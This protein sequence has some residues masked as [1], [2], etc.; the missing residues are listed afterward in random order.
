MAAFARLVQDETLDHLEESDPRAIRSRADLRRIHAVMGTRHILVK[1]LRHMDI[2]PRRMIELG[3]GEASLTLRV[4]HTLAREWGPVHLTLLDRQNAV[5]PST[6]QAFCHLGWEVKLLNVDILG[7]IKRP[8]EPPYD[9]ALVN[10]FLHHFR[11][12]E[13]A[14]ILTS[15]SQRARAICACEPRRSRLA[16]GG[17]HLVGLL[18]ANAVTRE[19]AVLSVRAGFVDDDLSRLMFPAFRGWHIEEYPA[20]LFTHCLAARPPEQETG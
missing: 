12:P 10:L 7:W 8:A 5:S 13:L 6:V 1:T 19:D 3:A 16:L 2:R 14:A 18:G 20:G 4:A 15:L 17:S 9:L 11:E